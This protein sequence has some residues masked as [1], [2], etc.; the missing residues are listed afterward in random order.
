MLV[1]NEVD[2]GTPA[3]TVVDIITKARCINNRKLDLEGLFLELSLDNFDLSRRR[4]VA[5]AQL[6]AIAY[7]GTKIL[8]YLC[9]LIKLFYMTAVVVF[10]GGELGCEEGVDERRLAQSG[11]ACA[12]VS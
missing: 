4:K 10:V 9:E 7:E 12:E 5:G 1:V 6:K 8:A 11:L 3:I 2:D